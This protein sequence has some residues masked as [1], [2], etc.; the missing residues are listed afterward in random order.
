[1]LKLHVSYITDA[2]ATLLRPD[3]TGVP[4]HIYLY[5]RRYRC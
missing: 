5:G 4:A 1:M 3:P 2:E